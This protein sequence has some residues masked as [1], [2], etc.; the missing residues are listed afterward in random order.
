MNGKERG[1]GNYYNKQG[2]VVAENKIEKDNH[3]IY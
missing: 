1:K 2:E 3:K